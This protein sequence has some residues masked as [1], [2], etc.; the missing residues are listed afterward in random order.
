MENLTAFS[1][2]ITEHNNGALHGKISVQITMPYRPDAFFV[3]NTKEI[4]E[5]EEQP[6]VFFDMVSDS[7]QNIHHLGYFF[8][9]MKQ[10]LDEIDKKRNK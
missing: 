9:I 7:S 8:S 4:E 6:D 5:G 10:V 1:V 2:V 3:S